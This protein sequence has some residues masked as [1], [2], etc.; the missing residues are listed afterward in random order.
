ML[1]SEVV[2]CKTVPLH[3]LSNDAQIRLNHLLHRPSEA[4]TTA[5]STYSLPGFAGPT[6]GRFA[7]KQRRK[8]QPPWG[9]HKVQ[10]DLNTFFSFRLFVISSVKFLSRRKLFWWSSLFR[11]QNS[12]GICCYSTSVCLQ[13]TLPSYSSCSLSL[14][15][16]TANCANFEGQHENCV[17]NLYFFP[18]LFLF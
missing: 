7:P 12:K 10:T 11:A 4:T 8:W 6:V 18:P 14:A 17:I 15:V 1:D 3:D 16:D 9:S 13:P 2:K 5:A